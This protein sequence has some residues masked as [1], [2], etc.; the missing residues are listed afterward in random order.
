V[1]SIHLAHDE[2]SG[3]HYSVHLVPY[4]TE[5]YLNDYQLSRKVSAEWNYTV[6]LSIFA[7]RGACG[8][9]VVEALCYKPESRG[10]ETRWAKWIVSLYL[11]LPAALGPGVYSASN[12][13]EYRK[14][15]KVFGEYAWVWQPHRHLWADCLDNVGS[16][17]H[18]TSYRP[19]RPVTG[20]A[21][22]LL[23]SSHFV[24]CFKFILYILLTSTNMFQPTSYRR[25]AFFLK[26]IDRALSELHVKSSSYWADTNGKYNWYEQPPY[27]LSQY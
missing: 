24:N 16:P 25:A 7:Y 14:Q 3:E 6:F 11:T 15:K 26:V 13:N 1:D 19:P 8:S 23:F 20:I 10:L 17:E 12:T 21:L 9:V 5:N 27:R 2:G 4:K 22:L 18:L